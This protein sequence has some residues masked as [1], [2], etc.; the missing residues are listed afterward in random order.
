MTDSDVILIQR[1]AILD[2]CRGDRSL[3]LKVIAE[4]G[5]AIREWLEAR[6]GNK[7]SVEELTDLIRSSASRSPA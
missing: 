7:I 3:A 2:F 1:E 6:R 5:A 4:Q